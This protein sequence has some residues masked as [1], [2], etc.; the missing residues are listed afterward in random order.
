MK[1]IPH[2][3]LATLLIYGCHRIGRERSS[4]EKPV[5]VHGSVEMENLSQE[6]LWVTIELCEFR[7]GRTYLAPGA[8]KSVGF[9]RFPIGKT[10]GVVWSV[11]PDDGS[12]WGP[13]MSVSFDTTPF[14]D[15]A[16]QIRGVHFVYDGDNKWRIRTY[17]GPIAGRDP[18]L[19][20]I[21]SLPP[22]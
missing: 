22:E 13:E 16:D 8:G 4:E 7:I 11:D 6:H 19:R 21:R 3:I 12:G 20:E 18:F 10:A 17:S 1:W 15:I 5:I 14:S 9:I 2:M